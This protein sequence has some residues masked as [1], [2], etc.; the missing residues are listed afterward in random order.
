M[1]VCDSGMNVNKPTTSAGQIES[2]A[3]PAL[4]GNQSDLTPK[5]QLTTAV[6][7]PRVQ[8]RGFKNLLGTHLLVVRDRGDR[9]DKRYIR[10]AKITSNSYIS[11]RLRAQ[12][13]RSKLQSD[14]GDKRYSFG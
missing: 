7:G 11:L 3:K 10:K 12:G 8:L 2:P 5:W 14:K 1:T 4:N 6:S 9:G 13:L